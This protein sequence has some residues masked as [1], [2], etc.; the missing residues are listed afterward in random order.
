MDLEMPSFLILFSFLIL[1]WI[2]WKKMNSNS[3]PPP[4]P[5]K[6]PL[7]GNILQLR[8]G[9]A[10]HR[11][12]DLAKVYGPVMSIQ[13]GQNP[14]VVLSSPEA[15]EQVFKIQGD[16]FNNRPPALSGKILF[17]NNSDM[18]FTPYGDHWRQIRKITVMEFLSPKRVLSFRSIREEQVSNFIK[19]LRTKGGSAINFPK[20]LSELTSRIMLITLLGNKDENE[21]IVLP[22]IERVI[23]TANKGAASDTFPTLKFFLDFLTGDKSRMEKVLQE[24]DIILEAIINEHKKKGTSEHNYLDFL[25]DK[26][27][28]GDLQLPLTNEAIKANLMAMYAGG[29][30]TSSKL[31]EWTFAEMMKNPETMRKAQE[32]VRRVFGDKGKVEESR[33]QEL[34]YLK[35]V[36]KESFRIHPPS[37]LITRVC[38]ERT[39]INGYDIHPKTTILI[40]VWTMGRDPNLWKEPE[41]FHPERFEDSKIDFRGANME[42]TP[43]GVGKRMC[44]GITLSTTYVE[45]LLANL[46]YHFDWKLPDGVTPATLDMTETLRG[47]LK[48]VQDLILIPIPFSPHQIA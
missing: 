17:Y 3:V 29:S 39:K 21:E 30:E 7:L 6:L 42:L 22:A 10:N 19:F 11:L 24:T 25:L 43:F 40:N 15:A 32:E 27:K 13:L 12:C 4:G 1:T 2:I 36:L 5:W 8:G 16:L 23:E 37:T 41:K 48:K 33:I 45:F 34:K 18:T 38:Q 31:I 28:K 35:L 47:T 14:A 20:A 44:P 46:L 26:Q 9:P